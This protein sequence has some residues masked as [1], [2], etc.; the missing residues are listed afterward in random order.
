MGISGRSLQRCLMER[1][2]SYSKIV[3]QVR[4]QIAHDLLVFC[5]LRVGEIA[6]EL[7]YADAGSFTRAFKRWSRTSPRTYRRQHRMKLAK[8]RA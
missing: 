2:I 3:D 8:Q 7:G 6:V 1:D 4:N 5:E